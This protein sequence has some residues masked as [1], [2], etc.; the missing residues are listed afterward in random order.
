MKDYPRVLT[1][2]GTPIRSSPY[3]NDHKTVNRT[4][5]E[6][7]FTLPWKPLK[8]TKQIY[9]PQVFMLDDGTIICSVNAFHEY[10]LE[11]YKK[12]IY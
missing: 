2:N 10:L 6:R 11:A 4:W 5:C 12:G 1:Y 7:L 9:S 8:T 3:I